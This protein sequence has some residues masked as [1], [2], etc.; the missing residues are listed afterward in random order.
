MLEE[1]GVP[2]VSDVPD[3]LPLL[4]PRVAGGE[5]LRA[6]EVDKDPAGTEFAPAVQAQY[7]RG[8]MARD[9]A[10]IM[11]VSAAGLVASSAYYDD[12]GL[13]NVYGDA[14]ALLAEAAA[15]QVGT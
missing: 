7:A 13:D 2:D 10:A 3:C 11:G 6:A 8:A 14:L 15:A 9:V 5:G 4:V 1:S 12:Y